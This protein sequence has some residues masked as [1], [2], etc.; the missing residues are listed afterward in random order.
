LNLENKQHLNGEQLL[1]AIVDAADLTDSVQAHLANCNRC[2][3][4]KNSFEQELFNLGRIAEKN[5]PQPQRR[6]IL[7]VKKA[8]FPFRNFLAWRNLVAAAATVAAVFLVV[9]GTN[10]VRNLS[11]SGTENLAAEMMEAE[12]LMS[13]V[14]TL[15][16]N[17]LPSFYLEIS[18]EKSPNYDEEFYRFLIPTIEDD[19]L[20][21]DRGKRGTSLC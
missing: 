11:K 5:V 3:A 7:P 19:M 20:T 13:E 14:N 4:E 2:L 16:D 17:A 15:V 12:K 1:Q 6:I 9:L 18:G 21:S 8:K 10:T